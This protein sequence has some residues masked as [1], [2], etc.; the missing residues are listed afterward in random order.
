MVV[1]REINIYRQ[2]T[3]KYDGCNWLASLLIPRTIQLDAFGTQIQIPPCLDYSGAVYRSIYCN[4]LRLLYSIVRRC[5]YTIDT[6]GHFT[7]SHGI[8]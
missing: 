6:Y 8:M 4:V 3:G 5:N 2:N 1:V 7:N